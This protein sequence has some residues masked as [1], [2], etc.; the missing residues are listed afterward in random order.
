[1]AESRQLPRG[2]LMADVSGLVLNDQEKEF[3]QHPSVGAVI[4]FSRNFIS[5]SQVTDLVAQ[6]KSIRQPQ[7]LVAVD[8]EG[9]RVQRFRDGFCS[10]PPLFSLGRLFDSSPAEAC[11]RALDA[12]RLMAAELRQVGIDFSFAPV[13]DLVDLDS[14]I[15]GDRGFHQQ[16]NATCQLAT[17]YIDGMESAGMSATGKHFPGHGGVT[18]DS[19]LELP[20]DLRDYQTVEAADLQPY[21][22]LAPKLGGIMT[23]HVLFEAIDP[24]LPTFSEFWI[25]DVLRQR[26]GF[27]GVVFSD[28]L[29]MEGAAVAG[30]VTDRAD[31]A[32]AA[33]CDMVLVCNDSEAAQK[34][35]LHL[36]NHPLPVAG[37]LEH[38]VGKP[39]DIG[40][41]EIAALSK[42]VTR[43]C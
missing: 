5:T 14:Q 8:Q 9:G 21:F 22:E 25:K 7:L 2:P 38:M 19:H 3:L 37:R 16:P 18:A 17:H 20:I 41:K 26:I 13:L 28:D 24:A 27:D 35:S 40:K 30:T 43:L 1:M 12:G 6:I 42:I 11:A 29:T 34:V 39:C 36:E 31:R 23:A 32:L 15:I 4:L 33:G 10:L